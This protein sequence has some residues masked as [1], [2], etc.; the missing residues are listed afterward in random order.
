MK[1]GWISLNMACVTKRQRFF[2]VTGLCFLSIAQVATDA[3]AVPYAVSYGRQKI[4]DNLGTNHGLPIAAYGSYA[5]DSYLTDYSRVYSANYAFPDNTFSPNGVAALNGG[6]FG[7]QSY[8]SGAF[9]TGLFLPYASQVVAIDYEDEP[10]PS[11][12]MSNLTVLHDW[13][14][15]MRGDYVNAIVYLNSWGSGG[16]SSFGG[17]EQGM[18]TYMQTARPDMLSFDDYPSSFSISS[19]NRNSWYS[20]TAAERKV[21]L[22]GY[23][24]TGTAPIVYGQFMKMYRDSYTSSLPS[25]SFVRMQRFVSLA[26][27]YQ[28]LNDYAYNRYPEA[29]DATVLFTNSLSA[30]S[31]PSPT[32]V[33]D[34][35]AEANRQIRNLSPALARM[36]STDVRMIPGSG[37]SVSGTGVSQFVVGSHHGDVSGNNGGNDYIFEIIPI[38]GPQGT[39]S[40][41]YEDVLIGYFD[42]LLP[43]NASCTFADGRHFMI[44]NA[45]TGTPFAYN[46]LSGDLASNS[47]Q[48]Y[49]LVFD[50][51][52]TDFDSLVRLNNDTGTVELVPLAHR[53]GQYYT[54]ELDLAGGTGNLF[55]FWDSSNPLPTIPEPGS[56]VL[57]GTGLIG[58]L[59][60][61]WRK[62]RRLGIG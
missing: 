13:Y 62:R 11:W 31:D 60:Y 17:T 4:L 47:Q 29:P 40:A 56:L 21:A 25:E 1:T 2:V 39:P 52:G 27:G 51:T 55:G 38:T 33:F 44:V 6:N 48:W 22:E 54:L 49:R 42:A 46:N 16:A 57:L 26:F 19:S 3:A 20:S 50:F 45:S 7:V 35:L 8:G 58:L 59:C 23:D 61:A 18:R 41:N 37:K 12:V 14:A 9:Q 15:K 43:D 34:Y 53:T 10:S 28:F 24:G 36:V 32:I 30:T 5:P